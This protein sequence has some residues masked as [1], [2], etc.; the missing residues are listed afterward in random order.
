MKFFRWILSHLTIIIVLSVILYVYLTQYGFWSDDVVEPAIKPLTESSGQQSTNK[1]SFTNVEDSL[2]VEDSLS[3]EDSV[4]AD[5]NLAGKKLVEEK[6]IENNSL[7][8]LAIDRA[9]PADDFSRRMKE[10]KQRLSSEEQK[11]MDN[12][13]KTFQQELDS[14][15]KFPVDAHSKPIV[16]TNT[17]EVEDVSSEHSSLSKKFPAQLI[18]QTQNKNLD[19]AHVK[20]KKA[21]DPAQIKPEALSDIKIGDDVADRQQKNALAVQKKR[22]NTQDKKLQQQ[23]RDRQ[24]QLQDKM[25]LLIP[26]NAEK[27]TETN[28]TNNK[29]NINIKTVKPLINTPEQK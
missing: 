4:S 1:E 12:A 28:T 26:L 18:E 3:V 7:Q 24:K 10:Y 14:E 19:S 17:V 29:K 20:E 13:A 5:N 2:Y 22:V 8:S 25:V 15:A 9:P 6:L 21:E 16:A 23:I 11:A 27:E